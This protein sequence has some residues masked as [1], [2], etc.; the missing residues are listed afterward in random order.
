MKA[1]L[2][3][4]FIALSAM[5]KKLERSH[6]NNLTTQLRAIEQKEANSPKRSRRQEIVKIRAETNQVETKKTIQRINETKKI[7]KIDK[8]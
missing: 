3:E 1:V 8:Y 4:K 6:T 7:N 5:V 2:R